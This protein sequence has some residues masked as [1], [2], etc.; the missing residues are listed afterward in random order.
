MRTACQQLGGN[1]HVQFLQD[2][3]SIILHRCHDVVADLRCVLF[4][5]SFMV[6]MLVHYCV[7]VSVK[8]RHHV[9]SIQIMKVSLCQISYQKILKEILKMILI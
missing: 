4:Y 1:A 7:S 6:A 2:G 8:I 5:V 3:T 9:A